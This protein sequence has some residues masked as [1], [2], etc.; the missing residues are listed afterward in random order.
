MEKGRERLRR[1]SWWGR[2]AR[3][4]EESIKEGR[5]K[6][7]EVVGEEGEKE[8]GR[9][10]TKVKAVVGKV[11]EKVEV[12]VMGEEGGRKRGE[13]KRKKKKR[14]RGKGCIPVQVISR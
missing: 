6:D 9:K 2:K 10:E 1:W 13:G 8:G 4:V 14:G 5:E 3:K 11:G 12:V 7:G